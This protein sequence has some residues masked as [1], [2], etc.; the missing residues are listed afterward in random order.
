[1]S[2]HSKVIRQ[3]LANLESLYVFRGSSC[4]DAFPLDTAKAQEALNKLDKSHE[5]LLEAAKLALFWLR[6]HP[7]KPASSMAQIDEAITKATKG[8][9]GKA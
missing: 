6:S 9:R 7:D 1:M 8:E 4:A 3:Q 2:E 5:E